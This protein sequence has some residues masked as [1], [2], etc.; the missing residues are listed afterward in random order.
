MDKTI[1]LILIMLFKQFLLKAQDIGFPVSFDNPL[2]SSN[3]FRNNLNKLQLGN[4]NNQSL[5]M[6]A[7]SIN[8]NCTECE[9]NYYFGKGINQSVNI[10]NSAHYYDPNVNNGKLWIFKIESPTAIGIQAYFNKFIYLQ[11]PHYL[12][13][14]VIGVLYTD[15]IHLL[16]HP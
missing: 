5:T 14:I 13:I 11:K 12:F 7:D 1:I 8:S 4:F 15:R 16:T 6:T 2:T 3:S 9:Y 10:K